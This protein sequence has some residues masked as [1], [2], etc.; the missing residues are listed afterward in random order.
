M[1]GGDPHPLHTAEY[2]CGNLQ[3]VP[4]FLHREAEIY[5]YGRPRR[6]IHAEIQKGKEG[7]VIDSKNLE[8]KLK[9]YEAL[10]KLIGQ[11]EVIADRS[12]Y[13]Q[14]ARELASLSPIVKRIREYEDLLK[15]VEQI[16]Q[17][18]SSKTSDADMK[19]LVEEELKTLEAKISAVKASLEDS[20]IGEDPEAG[21]NVIMEIRAGTG[22]L[23]ASLFAADIFRMY[24]K[25]A[26]RRNWK[27]EV[28]DSHPTD[29]GGFKE[30]IFSVE[31]EG[32]YRHLKFESGVHRVQRVPTTEA[33]GRIH[34][35]AVTVAVLPQAEEV[36]VDIKP[37]DI[38]VDVF[39]SS[40]KGGQGVNT[41]DS[42]VRITHLETGIVVTCQDER[43]Q[44]K[45]KQKAL[46][47]LRARLLQKI[48]DAAR[49]KITQERRAMVGTGDRSE[50]IRT[51]NFPDRRVTDHRINLTLHRLEEILEGDLDGLIQP[52]QQEERKALLANLK[53]KG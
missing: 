14:L 43:S 34:T 26:A 18:S 39:R 35:S 33:S 24:M 49:E 27:A 48:N 9:R 44:L 5:R 37:Q 17:M 41:T 12:Q 21:R 46:K 20:L 19:T 32:V 22:G 6:E 10:E 52:L 3:Q 42:A 50:K 38:R 53:G 15:Q 16:K 1:R 30:I 51:Y 8:E 4:S 36:E 25:Y 47:V 40:G 29:T 23:E 31:G 2:P 28:M 7:S 13:Q 11:P 45:N